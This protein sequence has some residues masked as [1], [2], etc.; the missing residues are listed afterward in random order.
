MG[1]AQALLVS[2]PRSGTGDRRPAIGPNAP[3]QVKTSFAPAT[4]MTAA[5]AR[6]SMAVE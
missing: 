4:T 1:L 6:R 5:K 3:N 2:P